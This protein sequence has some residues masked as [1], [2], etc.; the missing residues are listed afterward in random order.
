[1]GSQCRCLVSNVL[2]DLDEIDRTFYRRVNFPIP[3]LSPAERLRRLLAFRNERHLYHRCCDATG[4][5]IISFYPPEF[6]A[7]VYEK[8]YWW[9]NGWDA[10]SFGRPIDFTQPFFPQ[11]AAMRASVPRMNMVVSHCD[12]SDYAPYSLYCRNCFMVI[13]SLNSE[14]LRYCFQANFSSS[15]VDCALCMRCGLCAEC[16]YC[17]TTAGTPAHY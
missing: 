15:C 2:F 13:S 4:K 1:M 7:P 11:F 17:S 9:S 16:I 10:R 8:D 14:D 5:R 3:K 6:R 12:N